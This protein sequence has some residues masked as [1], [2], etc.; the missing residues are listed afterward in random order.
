[1]TLAAASPLQAADQAAT[2]IAFFEAWKAARLLDTHRKPMGATGLG[3]AEFVWRKWLAF[4]S[5]RRIDWQLATPDDV[6]SFAGAI[7]PRKLCAASQV[8]PLSRSGATG[9]S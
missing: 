6:R 1:M 9:A 4:C 8:S 5:V 3:Q 7:S 2:G